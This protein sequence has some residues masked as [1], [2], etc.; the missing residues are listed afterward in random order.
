MNKHQPYDLKQMQSLPL[1]AKIIMTQQRIRQWYDYWDGEVYVSFSGGKDSTVLKH[2]VD[3]MVWMS[4][5]L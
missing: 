4:G 2:I 1:E 3:S 5:L